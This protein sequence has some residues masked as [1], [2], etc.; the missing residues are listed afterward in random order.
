LNKRILDSLSA[1]PGL[2]AVA[3]TDDPELANH[4]IG[5]NITIAD[6]HGSDNENLNTEWPSVTPD[7]LATLNLPLIAGRS[8]GEGDDRPEA[9]KLAIVNQTF[10][11]KWMGTPDQALG[12]HFGMGGGTG[13][14]TD[15][16]IIGVVADSRHTNIRE[17]ILP[18]A[19]LLLQQNPNM[20]DTLTYY[21]RVAGD[22]SAPLQSV[23]TAVRTVDA[24]LVLDRFRTMEQQIDSTL[25]SENAT[26]FLATSF[27]IFAALLSAV[28]LYGVLAYSATQRT[29]EIGIR[30]ALGASRGSVIWIFTSEIVK[31]AGSGIVIA[32]P[33]AFSGSRFLKTQLF[34]IVYP[35]PL[36]LAEA[37]ALIIVVAIAGALIP[38]LRAARIDPNKAL[39]Y[40]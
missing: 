6:Y 23:R 24:S 30:M 33:I 18:T 10:V 26:A 2:R 11:H 13:V 29:R 20:V 14:Q 27:G 17:E 5:G 12:R 25:T 1:L 28:G 21:L 8:F 3:A 37:V 32:L 19:Y 39:R 35:D 4:N 38:C 34:G 9:P 16:E 36:I 22:T 31:L 40:E 15:I 7:Y